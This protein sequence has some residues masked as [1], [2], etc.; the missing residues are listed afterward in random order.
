MNGYNEVLHRLL[1]VCFF[2]FFLSLETRVIA[3]TSHGCI[4]V[5]PSSPR[6]EVGERE[7]RALRSKGSGMSLG[8][9]KLA[10]IIARIG[11]QGVLYARFLGK[12]F[13][14]V[15]KEWI[16]LQDRKAF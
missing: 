5:F 12:R 9:L 7:A 8:M 15:E 1:C 6:V 10:R 2:F 16:H 3:I 4:S 14:R 11:W 13:F